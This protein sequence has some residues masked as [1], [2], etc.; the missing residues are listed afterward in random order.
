MTVNTFAEFEIDKE[1]LELLE[2]SGFI[3]AKSK[4]GEVMAKI[5]LEWEN[6]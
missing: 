6:P 3:N 4:D 2:K 1:K 5:E